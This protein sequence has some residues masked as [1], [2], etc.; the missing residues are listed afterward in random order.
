MSLLG[1]LPLSAQLP[2]PAREPVFGARMP[3]LSPLGDRVAFVYR[4][5]VWVARVEDGRARPLAQHIE[6]DA[7]PLFS[8]DGQWVAFSSKRTGNW[9]LFAV[10]AEGGP[11][12]QLTWHSGSDQAFGWR[13]DG[14]YLL[15]S[16]RRDSPNYQLFALDAVT[17][18]LRVLAEDYSP[19]M[20]PS[21]S[22]DGKTVV[23]GRYGF[24]W[25]RPRYVGSAAAQICLLNVTNGVRRALTADDRQHLW[26]KFMPDGE[27]LLTVTVGEATPAVAKVDETVPRFV[28]NPKRTPNL[29]LFDLNGQG[30]QLTS[31]S[32]GSV[33]W[34]SVATGSGDVAFEYGPDLWLLKKGATEPQKITLYAAADEKQTSRRRERLNKEVTE[35]EP[36]PDGK[37]FAFGLRGD[38]WSV[39][40][41]RPKG[42]AGRNSEYARRLTDWAGD[43][44][45]FVWS[46]S[47]RRLFFTSDRE[48]YTRIF[49][50]ELETLQ[51][52]PIW[53]RNSD[54]SRLSV[55][56][57]GK[58]LGFWASGPEG[59]LYLMRL[60]T[61]ET[62]C[63]V[64]APG[65]QW[66]GQGGGGD[67]AWSPDMRWIAYSM[68][69]E[70]KAWNIWVV[71]REGGEPRNITQ[72]YAHHGQPAWS[73]DGKYLYFQSNR[74]GA[75]LYVLPL[76]REQA[77]ISDT[78][79]KFEK[80]TN[81]VEVTIDFDG[82]WRRIRKLASQEPQADLTAATDGSI[83][84]MSE[85]DVWSVSY[86]GKETK[87][88]TTGGGKSGL[89][90]SRD[91]RKAYYIQSGELYTLS[92]GDRH[93]EKVTFVADWERDVRAE[94]K[95][96]FA[97]F[98]RNYQRGFY[99][100]AFH[101]RNWEEIRSRYEPLL[102]AVE[103][104]DE[105]A[106][107]LQAMVGELEASHSEVT[108]A[109][110]LVSPVTPQLGFTFDYSYRGPGLR[111]RGVPEGAPGSFPKTQIR[112]GEYIW[113]IN[114]R[115]VTLDEKLYEWLNDKQDRE[116]DFLVS[117][118][119]DRSHAR[120]VR[121]KALTQEEWGELNYRNRTDRLRKQVAEKSRGRIGYLHLPAMGAKDQTQFEKEAYEYMVGK[122]AMIL[123]VRFNNGGNIADTLVEWLSRKPFGYVRPRDGAKEPTPYHAWDQKTIVLMN[124]HSYSNGEIF[125]DEMRTRGLARLVGM[126]T[127]GYVIW[128]DGVR[129]VDGTAARLPMSGAFRLD[130]TNMENRGEQPDVLVPMSAEDWLEG[131]DPQ[132]DKAIELLLAK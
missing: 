132:L 36:S 30:R 56:P 1:V 23:Y 65:P 17:L 82:I 123:D 100:P 93:E 20:F 8:P 19:M 50:L 77:R 118:N 70:S 119:A 18:R 89:R 114:G 37:T 67:F 16:G 25:S 27:H 81:A 127:P 24:H 69:G 111:V 98:W 47:G 51:V 9:D 76:T 31:F 72:L 54:A 112:P 29:W 57:D 105:F 14:K 88:L 108:A 22:P 75:G 83:F 15:F 52:K 62:Q 117:T 48:Q 99:D 79:L 5:D 66:R 43:D 10:P 109:S 35:A 45:D 97:Q 44:S 63:L 96:A 129:L 55:S 120:T 124:E 41:D 12:R 6:T 64:S 21:Y 34:P 26:T 2:T 68:R 126:P 92:V 40:I 85:N 11:A 86:D 110:T 80:S 32:G 58:W 42:V 116:L 128:T 84:F 130:G 90:V 115:D 59:G 103:T 13:P 49:E 53:T 87:R 125:P 33:R 94:R 106:A 121:Y 28:D 61:G 60:D 131:R 107:L 38:I 102:D 7:Y 78:D 4:G 104:N 74:D 113:Q 91:G 122:E 46:G 73:A 39:A 3:A 95:A 101:G 71:P